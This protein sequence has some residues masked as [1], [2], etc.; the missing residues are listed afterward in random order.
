M[1]QHLTQYSNSHTLVTV[2][3]CDCCFCLAAALAR[4]V[5]HLYSTECLLVYGPMP[6]VVPA[7]VHG[8]VSA[9]Y[10]QYYY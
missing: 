5:L 9:T 7:T 3:A 10:V 2:R 6:T 4:A 1:Q 8:S